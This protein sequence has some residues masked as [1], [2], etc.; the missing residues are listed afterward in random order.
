MMLPVLA[1]SIG[2]CM[3]VH[4]WAT[5]ASAAAATAAAV[6]AGVN[7]RLTGRREHLSWM[8]SALEATFVDFLSASYDH[9]AASRETVKVRRGGESAGSDAEWRQVAVEAND[10]MMKAIARGRELASDRM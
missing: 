9:R 2:E 1:L 4:Q 6:L 10:I 8:R 7:L 5:V 3:S